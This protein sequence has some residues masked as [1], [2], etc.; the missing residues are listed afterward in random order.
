[1]KITRKQLRRL[2]RETLLIEAG[3]PSGFAQKLINAFKAKWWDYHRGSSEKEA[4][5]DPETLSYFGKWTPK[6]LPGDMSKWDR[7]S[8]DEKRLVT[9]A[10]IEEW[11][12]NFP[13]S[14]QSTPEKASNDHAWMTAALSRAQAGE[15]DIIDLRDQGLQKDAP[16]RLAYFHTPTGY[17]SPEPSQPN[18]NPGAGLESSNPSLYNALFAKLDEISTMTTE[19]DALWTLIE[20]MTAADAKALG[21]SAAWGD[22]WDD[23]GYWWGDAINDLTPA[24]AQKVAKKLGL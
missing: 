23:M 22:E 10:Y 13:D 14:E 9:V 20:N 5:R 21:L 12:K 8:P 11:L 15:L 1:M 19:S 17:E 24:I 18:Q 16:I 7:L 3:K 4:G 6:K 2:I